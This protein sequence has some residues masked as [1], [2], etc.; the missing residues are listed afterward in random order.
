M[1]IK[2]NNTQTVEAPKTFLSTSPA[3]TGT[4]LIVKNINNFTENWYAQVGE[5][6]GEKTEIKQVN[7]AP[8]GSTVP[9]AALSYTH[10]IDT[11]VYNVKY[12]QIIFKVST[13]GTSG[14]ATAITAGTVSITPDWGYTQFDHTAGSASYAYKTCYRSSANA[15]VSPD[16]GWLTSGGY[17]QFSLAHMRNRVKAK[18]DNDNIPDT[19]INDW[20]NEWLE[21]MN[22]AVISVNEDYALGTTTLTY[23]G[24]ATEATIT[25]SDFQYVRKV[26]Y[27]ESGDY[28]TA[29]KMEWSN[30][31][32][33]DVYSPTHPF[34]YMKDEKTVGRVPHESSGTSSITYYKL[35][36]Q[37]QDDTDELPAPLKAHTNSFVRWALAQAKRRADEFNVASELEISALQDLEKFKTEIAPRNKSGPTMIDIVEAFQDEVDMF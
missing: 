10:P 9:V 33:T 23:S 6:G 16:S 8:S 35:P 24:T 2:V 7:G 14:T 17:S 20:I 5:T 27:T 12:D 25:E 1:I 19:D 29:T 31:E 28:Y 36:A 37:L 18:V 34:Y 11:P 22:N 30:V 21:T 13:A 26:E 3:A 32:P 15:A 4:A